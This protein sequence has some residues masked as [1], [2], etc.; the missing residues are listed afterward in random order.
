VQYSGNKTEGCIALTFDDGPIVDNTERILNILK[1]HAVPAAFFCVGRR[2][3]E[4]SATAKRIAD[5]GHI[6]GNHSFNHGIFFDLQSVSAITAELSSTD[7]V[8]HAHTG[9]VPR[10]FR[11]P[12]G[13]TNPMVASAVQRKGYVTVGWS[14]R[15][16]DTITK[17]SS[18]LLKKILRA[19]FQRKHD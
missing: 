16:F 15:S 17:N 2:V 4:N 8:I 14:I 13:V 6:L 10:F 19:V 12:Y 7:D 9:S 3:K 18:K 11:P 1:I 5:E